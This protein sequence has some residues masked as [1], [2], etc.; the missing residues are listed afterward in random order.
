[1]S[2]ARSGGKQPRSGKSGHGACQFR[3]W[4]EKSSLRWT[5]YASDFS[6]VHILGRALLQHHS[7]TGLAT[8]G[9]KVWHWQQRKVIAGTLSGGLDQRCW[10]ITTQHHSNPD[11]KK[12][13]VKKDGAE[14]VPVEDDEVDATE[15]GGGGEDVDSYGEDTLEGTREAN[16]EGV[17]EGC[18]VTAPQGR[19]AATQPH[20]CCPN[21]SFNYS[22]AL[23]SS[24]NSAGNSLTV[25]TSLYRP[26]PHIC[27]HYFVCQL[28]SSW[29]VRL[30]CTLWTLLPTET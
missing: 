6:W 13:S 18:L 8:F 17:Q 3:R 1:M 29:H 9:V 22:T 7:D 24:L 12:T 28:C 21:K 15:E 23:L 2:I 10:G 16:T 11:M 20:F 30:L 19:P 26:Q 5:N 25:A 27:Q 4:R 14:Q